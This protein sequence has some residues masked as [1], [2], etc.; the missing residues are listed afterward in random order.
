MNEFN[1]SKVSGVRWLKK[2]VE[3][4]RIKVKL[5]P[6]DGILSLPKFDEYANESNG[7]TKLE[8]KTE[9][10]I[11][12]WQ[13]KVFSAWELQRYTD[14]HNCI[15]ETELN[16]NEMLNNLD[17]ESSK[18]FT[19][20]HYDCHL[21]LPSELKNN[22]LKELNVLSLNSCLARLNLDNR[23]G[24]MLEDTSSMGHLFKSTENVV[25]EE[26]PWTA[27][28][29]VFDHSDYNEDSQLLLKQDAIILSLYYNTI[30]N[31][32]IITPDVNN[33]DLNPY[34]VESETGV[35][36]GFQYSVEV[37]FEETESGEELV[38]LL[39]KLH[40]KWERQ[41][42]QVV[43]FEMPPLGKKLYYV[44]LE[45]VTATDFDVD[46]LYI[47]FTIQV[48]DDIQCND[49]L[50]GRSHLAKPIRTEDIE[51]WHFS[52]I[53]ELTLEMTTDSESAP[54]QV[55][56]EAIS[57]DWWG[58]HRTEGYSY[59]PLSLNP[60]RF[61]KQLSCSR[62]EELDSVE[63]EN[64]RFFVG[65]CH[66]IKDLEIFAKPQLH[67]ANFKFVTTGSINVRWNTIS[68]TCV[69]QGRV[70]DGREARSCASALLLGAEAVLRQY[71]RAR[72]RL[73]AA[74]HSLTAD[75]ED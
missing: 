55:F 63:A 3:N 1:R 47:E 56:F 17:Y 41:Q 13:E 33:L 6:Q 9:E 37:D 25:A 5:K 38:T 23:F 7:L 62:P 21:P 42:K 8:N 48:P 39:R 29:V 74:T 31:Y 75:H 12:K 66:L 45:L 36:W 19:Y 43:N 58:R 14:V 64:R 60:G 49:A 68:Q 54:I 26:E 15:S 27:M 10:Y 51:E 57:T 46:D 53:I 20:I 28:H 69:S 34:T 52:H 32:L 30:H 70:V 65:G 61:S 24:R 16:Y 59:L 44:T 22:N 40:Q 72:A 67:D 35:Q 50:H 71:R 18:I 73:A 11:F 2:P 4:I